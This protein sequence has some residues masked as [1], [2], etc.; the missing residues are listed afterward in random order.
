MTAASPLAL[1]QTAP[2]QTA[3]AAT[4]EEVVVTG[5]RIQQSPND[6]SISPVTSVT[7]V[8]IQ[9]TGLTRAEDLLNNLPQVVA[10]Q[11]SGLAI[12]SNGTATISLRGLGSNRTLVLVNGR[13]L[14]PGGGIGLNF[15]SVPDINQIPADLIE[16]ADVLTGG[17]SAVYGADAV[18]GVVNFV[19][20][21]KYQGVKL[22]ANYSFYNHK[23]DSAQY[24]GYLD[25]AGYPR[26]PSTVNTGQTK[27][28]SLVAGFNFADDRGNASI[29]ATYM[30]TQPVA[31]YQID[32][33]GC[34]L[35][36]PSSLPGP[37]SIVC[38]GSSTSATG[39]FQE[40]GLKGT[41]AK[42]T[43]LVNDTVDATTGLM[44]PFAQKDY[45]NYGALSYFQRGAERFTAGAFLHFDINDHTNIY[46]EFMYARNTSTAQYGPSGAFA[47]V[48]FKTNCSNP[49]FT[50]QEV[51][52]LCD[53]TNVAENQALYGLTNPGDI[54]LRI[55]R[56]NV[57]G[58]GRLDN[59]ESNSFK[60]TVG[61]KGKF[62]QAWSYDVYGQIGITHFSNN[63]GNFLGA[64]QVNLAL[65]VVANPATGGV[66]GVAPGAP[67]CASR[68]NGTDPNC[69][70]W[71]IYQPGGVTADQLTYLTVPSTFSTKTTEYITSGSVTG[72]LG[73]YG[74]KLPTAQSG[75]VI[76]LGAEY[77]QETYSFDP[78]YIYANG[79]ASGGNGAAHPIH[80]EFHV[81]ELFTEMRLPIVDEKPGFYDLSAEA[82]YR[83]S[84]YTSGFNTNTFKI[85]LEWAPVQDVRLRG[86]Y[87]RAIRAPSL[88]DLY[89]P[90]IVGAGGTADPCW[91]KNPVYTPAQCARTGVTALE[92]GNIETNPAAQINNVLS[93]NINLKPE[94][95]DTYSF[96][97]VWQ[98]QAIRGLVMSL[99]Y[100]DIKIK[101]TI[102][103]LSTNTVIA[104]CANTG[105]ASLCGLIHRG[106]DGSLWTDVT[107]FVDTTEQNIGTVKT[108]GVDL[109]THYRLDAGSTGK[110]IFDLTGT[111]VQ[112]FVTQPLPTGGSYD[113]AGLWGSTCNAPLPRWRHVLNTTWSTPWAGLDVTARWRY[114][115]HSDVDRSSSNPLLSALY[116]QSTAHIPAYT[117]IDLSASMPVTSGVSVRLGVNN[118]TDKNPPLVLNGTYSDCPNTTCNDNTWAGTYDALGRY[119]YAHVSAKF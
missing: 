75:L 20:N 46:S 78:D 5:S 64:Q 66:V 29:Y 113:C 114:I 37:S 96:G 45:Y 10:E 4:Q 44:R 95:A 62:G 59:Y 105:Q 50:A 32:H 76:N 11:G 119:I 35:N 84:D 7:S 71:N 117:Y 93:G 98:P 92:Y 74:V 41:P 30:N 104:N 67:V 107:D 112:S 81:S 47:Y 22:D 89:S 58:G 40:H 85:G 51:Q 8:D 56:R 12:S 36:G 80:G 79:F 34:T 15:G 26:P 106:A 69:V 24:L 86:S 110:F 9:Q 97:V 57:E 60:E 25:S 99:D 31:G 27:D 52:V 100:Y 28:L 38:G 70:P 1:A 91:G 42:D 49:L 63:E 65:D 21:T 102:Q 33:A 108:A 77:R 68:L 54:M 61:L 43:T 18:A 6:V 103:T 17:A 14:N 3:P 82:G 2:V 83:Y 90:P 109:K 23:N 72:D 48:Q 111:R 13:R 73:K 16:R 101:D 55:A 53:P 115:G 118:L 116:Y 39:K 19:L 94:T 88:S 87:N